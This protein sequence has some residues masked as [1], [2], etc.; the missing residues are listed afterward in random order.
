MSQR[1]LSH[2]CKSSEINVTQTRIYL[3][4]E[5]SYRH[6]LEF[7][8]LFRWNSSTVSST[9]FSC[10][11][12]INSEGASEELIE[13]NQKSWADLILNKEI[14]DLF[15]KQY[16]YLVPSK[17]HYKHHKK[18]PLLQSRVH[19]SFVELLNE[20]SLRYLFIFLPSSIDYLHNHFKLLRTRKK[21]T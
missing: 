3:T 19:E 11:F 10:I 20:N 17:P 9:P 12:Q 21:K 1:W 8:G 16:I 7:K 6:A 2:D 5:R 4:N 14:K 18:T 13:L 15:V